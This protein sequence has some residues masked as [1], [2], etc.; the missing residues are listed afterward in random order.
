M[1]GQTPFHPSGQYNYSRDVR[2][3][4][5]S[6]VE[7]SIPLSR[8]P[9]MLAS[10][11][12]Q[13]GTT[14]RTSM[15][16]YYLPIPAVSMGAHVD[17][18]VKRAHYASLNAQFLPLG[19]DVKKEQPLYQPATEAI[20]PINDETKFDTHLRDTTIIRNTISKLESEIG[21]TQEK[22]HRAKISR[23]EIRRQ[24]AD[25]TA[26]D[27]DEEIENTIQINGSQ[28]LIEKI[29]HENRKTAEDGQ[30]IL[31]QLNNQMDLVV[32][33][34]QEPNDL[35][36]ISEIRRKYMSIMKNRLVN[37]FKKSRERYMLRTKF[38]CEK[39]DEVYRK[40]QK[41]IEKEEK[42]IIGKDS[43]TYRET[44]EK[45][46]PELRKARE[47]KEKKQTSDA[48]TNVADG[49]TTMNPSNVTNSVEQENEEDDEKMRKLSVVPPIL[50]DTWQR[51][52]QYFNQNGLIKGDVAL[53]YKDHA[54]LPFWSP[55]EKQIFIEKFTQ[56]PKNFGY[57]SLFLENKTT[58]ECVQFYY[59]TKKTENYKSLLRKQNQPLRRRARQ[60]PTATMTTTTVT[61]ST[62]IETTL[63]TKV[64]SSNTIVSS[65]SQQ[66]LGLTDGQENDRAENDDDRRDLAD[67]NEEKRANKS[68]CQFLSCTTG[69]K[70]TRKNRL[71]GF[72]RQWNELTDDHRE[73]IRRS[74]KIPTNVQRCCKCCYEK[75]IPEIRQRQDNQVEEDD[76]DEDEEE[77]NNDESTSISN[78]STLK[79]D[80]DEWTAADIDAFTQAVEKYNYNWR[81]IAED[82]QRSEKS[83]RTFYQNQ[84]KVIV[85]DDNLDD[86]NRSLSDS[87]VS[88][89]KTLQVDET[90]KQNLNDDSNDSPH[91]MIIDEGEETRSMIEENPV[92][93][94]RLTSNP[95]GS[96]LTTINSLVEQ[97]ISKTLHQTEKHLN[98]SS[99][100]STDKV[101]H[102]SHPVIS[103]APL[104]I[105]PVVPPAAATKIST[106]QPAAPPPPPPPLVIPV[107]THSPPTSH[108]PYSS[109]SQG[110]PASAATK[111]SI[112]R[113]TPISASAGMNKTM[114]IETPSA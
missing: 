87:E 12:N 1:S 73:E 102:I 15:P 109:Y 57:I 28:T 111:G 60:N 25:R 98:N 65:T 6:T 16:Q 101:E 39:Y 78:R 19:I 34:Y 11:H 30:K 67:N 48:S 84:Q 3:G 99:I 97:E 70:K 105:P 47:D 64:T 24:A 40:W 81:E 113:G 51:K 74:L 63:V 52:H 5:N 9:S 103:S 13:Y 91:P 114:P 38:A 32:P 36:S 17:E 66:I 41:S 104:T 54:K 108:Y 61:S 58:E 88:T 94:P 49:S 77:E 86:D 26:V 93:P 107:R 100:S 53:F 7:S 35:D 76:D 82:L 69:K 22:L 59:M 72:P 92:K 43:S 44:F 79:R 33:L 20:S 80:D 18:N 2:Y 55:E 71:R 23:K 21:M 46:F 10:Y 14:E 31:N 68:R 112:M 56:S 75:L 37:L 8:R 85:P 95:S 45:T 110:T 83:C 50:Y 4:Q 90:V 106:S 42:S 62:T 29:L 96:N 27:D 89:R